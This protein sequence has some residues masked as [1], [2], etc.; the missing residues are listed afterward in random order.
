MELQ[1]FSCK[2]TIPS[3]LLTLIF[4]RRRLKGLCYKGFTYTNGE[5]RLSAVLLD[6]RVFKINI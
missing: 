1:V 5:K 6:K 3:M 4:I 2:I